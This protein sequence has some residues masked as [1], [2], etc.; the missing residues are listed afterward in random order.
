M[1]FNMKAMFYESSEALCK[2]K[3]TTYNVSGWVASAKK[4]Q[5]ESGSI[6]FTFKFLL[7]L[8][9]SHFVYIVRKF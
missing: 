3:R 7:T 8:F 4:I 1:N 5:A 2:T 9:L 6:S